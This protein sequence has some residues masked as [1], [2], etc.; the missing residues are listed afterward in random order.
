MKLAV[1]NSD[2]VSGQTYF[3]L[4]DSLIDQLLKALG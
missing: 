4:I 3:T 1:L 2:V